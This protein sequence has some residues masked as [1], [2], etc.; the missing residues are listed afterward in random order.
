MG[1]QVTVEQL[2]PFSPFSTGTACFEVLSAPQLPGWKETEHSQHPTA[3][4]GA[5]IQKSGASDHH[6]RYGTTE[7][8]P[9]LLP[10][11]LPELRQEKH[12]DG[13]IGIEVLFIVVFH[14][15]KGHLKTNSTRNKSRPYKQGK[16]R[17][18]PSV[19]NQ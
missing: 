8:H 7:L 16:I 12:S 1:L 18:G 6:K 3:Q 5:A 19:I 10:L 17:L 15:P 2:L 9:Q 14:K 13:N 11:P 4:L